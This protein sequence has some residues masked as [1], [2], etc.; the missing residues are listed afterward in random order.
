[1]VYTSYKVDL[2]TSLT[3]IGA[4]SL[5]PAENT[6]PDVVTARSGPLTVPSGTFV[7]GT[8][9]NPFS[10]FIFD[11]PYTYTGGDLLVTV[12]RSLASGPLLDADANTVGPFLDSVGADQ[13]HYY[14]IPVMA[15]SY[16][17]PSAPILSAVA[18]SGTTATGTT[19]AATSDKASTGYWIATADNALPP[20]AEQVKL[21]TDYSAV[22]VEAVG[23]GAMSAGAPASF[24]ITGLV[25]GIAYDLYIVA[26]DGVPNLSDTVLT[27]FA[28]YCSTKAV[29]IYADLYLTITASITA[30]KNAAL[31]DPVISA[32]V[33]EFVEDPTFSGSGLVTFEGGYTCSFIGRPGF[34]MVKGLITISGDNTVVLDKIIIL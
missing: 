32:N 14:N 18:V 8:V 17:V 26:E 28:T 22:T 23:S 33:A 9:P 25:E 30:A 21:G 4:M 27:H 5:V 12:T 10:Y 34:S 2:S 15:F 19:L 16:T 31:V 3:A 13:T 6:G 1:M 20:I 24:D 11:R 7:G 29:K